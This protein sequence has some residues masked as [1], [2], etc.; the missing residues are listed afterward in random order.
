MET[1]KGARLKIMVRAFQI[2]IN[3]GESFEKIAKDYP[4]LTQDDLN[5]IKKEL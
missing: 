1:I 3:N 2:R 4:R 5:A